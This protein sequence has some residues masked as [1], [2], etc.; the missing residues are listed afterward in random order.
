[1]SSTKRYIEIYKPKDA[2]FPV[3]SILSISDSKANKIKKLFESS[4]KYS[5]KI[6]DNIS[7]LTDQE[8]AAREQLSKGFH[9]GI[10]DCV[11]PST[12]HYNSIHFYKGKMLLLPEPNQKYIDII[13]ILKPVVDY[14][15]SVEYERIKKLQGIFSR[16]YAY[17]KK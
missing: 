4:S 15:D 2:L 11:S 7:H 6:F 12:L 3:V 16:S 1:M 10:F 9:C 8:S 17:T 5:I 14:K 13:E